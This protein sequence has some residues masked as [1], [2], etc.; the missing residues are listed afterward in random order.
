MIEILSKTDINKV[1]DIKLRDYLVYSFNRLP[2]DYIYPEYGY[3]III[4]DFKELNSHKI[5][6]SNYTINSI[7]DGMFEDINIVEIN[8]EIIEILVFVDN[9][10]SVSFI[11][12]ENIIDKETR[13][14]LEEYLI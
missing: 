7:Q 14:K 9:E 10:I 5:E 13:E 11:M 2:E 1:M 6:L 3:F 12:Y 8:G 4:E